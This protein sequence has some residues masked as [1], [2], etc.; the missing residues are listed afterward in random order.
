MSNGSDIGA[1]WGIHDN[2]YSWLIKGSGFISR[3]VLL[4]GGSSM[5]SRNY[6]RFV[7][8]RS[9]NEYDYGGGYFF[10]NGGGGY[11]YTSDSRLKENIHPIKESESITFLKHLQPS[12][13]CM[14]EV[15]PFEKENADGTKEIVQSDC[16]SCKQDGFIA[17]NVWDA[18]VASGVSKSVLNH[19]SGWLE[20][21]KKPEEERTLGKDNILG[22]SDRPILSHTV[23]VVKVLMER[24]DT[25]EAREAVW[26]EH[27]KQ[28]EAQSRESLRTIEK[29]RAD[30]EKLA[31][32]VS[33][34]ISTK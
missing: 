14:K 25:L 9:A 29:L 1:V 7:V 30:V 5:C 34:L 10:V 24:V 11:G 4:G 3:E 20:E 22:V 32:I 19:W 26:V 2:V 16:C 21:M 28:Q 8:W 23:N 15:K 13:F 33:Q 6:D 17:D 18:V 31:S 12:S 27:A